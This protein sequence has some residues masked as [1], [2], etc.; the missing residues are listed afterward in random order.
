MYLFGG[1]MKKYYL[2]HNPKTYALL[3][4][5]DTER[6]EKLPA[7][8]KKAIRLYLDRLHEK[9]VFVLLFGSTAKNTF[10]EESDIDLLLITNRKIDA[11][12]AEK[13]AEVLTS[14]KISTFQTGFHRFREE[15]K[16]KDDAVIQSA[17]FSGYPIYNHL[18][19]Y[20]EIYHERV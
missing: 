14:I 4:L 3:T 10:S 18:A 2:S 16:L 7:L 11:K 1:N 15:I 17:L 12:E 5:F 6:F 19:Y 9:P 13:E 20:E 8:R